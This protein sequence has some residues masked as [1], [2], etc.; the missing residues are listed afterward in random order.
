[1]AVDRDQRHHRGYYASRSP[2]ARPSGYPV[3]SRG[4]STRVSSRADSRAHDHHYRRASP[5]PARAQ[6]G[7]RASSRSLSRSR[8]PSA[9]PRARPRK[10]GV[11]G[12]AHR[13][14]DYAAPHRVDIHAVAIPPKIQKVLRRGF[15]EVIPLSALTTAACA[16]ARDAE[17]SSIRDGDLVVAEGKVTLKPKDAFDSSR[18]A[19]LTPS[20]FNDAGKNLAG[21]IEA[22]F[23][24]EGESHVGS[25]AAGAV[26]AMFKRMFKDIGDRPDF[27]DDFDLYLRYVLFMIRY[28][29]DHPDKNVVLDIFDQELYNTLQMK[30]VRKVLKQRPAEPA[31]QSFLAPRQPKSQPSRAQ[32]AARSDN[33]GRRRSIWRCYLCAKDHSERV[34]T[35]PS[36]HLIKGERGYADRDGNKYCIAF[37]TKGCT[38]TDCVFKHFC[39]LCGADGGKGAQDCSCKS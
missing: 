31:P 10:A 27:H 29:V 34:H 22:F 6:A 26:G 32:P 9:T 21:A 11:E 18:D 4:H 25:D 28:W 15:H 12:K 3:G 24:P 30:M 16:A 19:L 17:S 8:S 36:K 7:R 14:P 20:E 39:S 23:I 35:G 37:N 1:M 13:A 5:A 33:V 38:R 2:S